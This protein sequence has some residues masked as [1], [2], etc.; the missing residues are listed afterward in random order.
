[1]KERWKRKWS[2][3]EV[4]GVIMNPKDNWTFQICMFLSSVEHLTHLLLYTNSSE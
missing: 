1:M 4:E 3:I 2:E